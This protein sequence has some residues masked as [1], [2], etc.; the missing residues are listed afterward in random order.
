MSDKVFDLQMNI[1]EP[2]PD[3]F[4]V[5][6]HGD[7][8][9]NNIMFQH[10]ENGKP[11]DILFVDLQGSRYGSPV[12]DLIYF[13]VTS[14]EYSIKLKEFD[15]MIKYYHQE[16]VKNLK[17]LKYPKAPPKLMDLHIAA[18][19]KSFIGNISRFKFNGL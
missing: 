3:E 15:Y 13:I 18:V 14:T 7:L 17:L 12:Q 5:V 1:Y 11:K 4:N 16:L 6:L 9:A 19:K 8:W 2:N 10:D